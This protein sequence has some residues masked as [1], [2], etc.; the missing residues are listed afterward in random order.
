MEGPQVPQRPLLGRLRALWRHERTPQEGVRENNCHPRDGAIE[1]V[2]QLLKGTRDD[3]TDEGGPHI[4]ILNSGTEEEMTVIGYQSCPIR[5]TIYWCMVFLTVGIL[6]L[7]THWWQ[8]WLLIATHKCCPLATAQKVL[9]RELY[10][11]KHVIHFVCEIVTLS[12]DS[13]E[14][15][16]RYPRKWRRYILPRDIEDSTGTSLELSVPTGGGAFASVDT[17]RLFRCKQLRYIWRPSCNAFVR[18]TGLDDGVCSVALHRHKG[19]NP[20]EQKR[21]RMVFGSNEIDIPVKGVLTLLFLEVL[22]PFY[23]FQIFSVCLWF[24]YN[25]IWYAIVIVA[26]SVFGIT[27][28]VIQTR[29]NQRALMGTVGTTDWICVCREDGTAERIETR[30]LVPGDILEIPTTGC[31]MNCDAVLLSGNAI[32]DESSLTGES[33]PVTKTPLPCRREVIL[34]TK[35]HA[36]HM[37]FTGTKVIQTRYIGSEKVL[38][39]VINT[40]NSTVKGG[41]IRSI[42]YPPPVDYKFERDS[43]HFIKL[44]GLVATIGFL[45]TLISKII[46]GVSATKIAIES[47]DIIT[48]A[49]PP[50]LP[51]AMTVGRM[52][53][54]QRLKRK[55]IYCISPRSI[56]VSG[57]IDCVCF[58]KTGTLTEEGLDMWGVVP[59]DSQSLK[60][61]LRDVSRL[62]LG[63]LLSGMVTCHSITMMEGELK[64]DPLDLKMF[65]ST[66]W[67]LEE[68][69]V[70]DHSKYDLLFPTVVR[71]PDAIEGAAIGIVRSFPFTSTLQ[72]M[73]VITRGLTDTHF[74]VYCKGSPEMI[75]TLCQ[76]DTIPKDFHIKLDIYAQQGYRIIA[77]AFRPLDKKVSYARLQRLS[78][79]SVEQDLTFLGFVILENR[80]KGDTTTVISSL[81][82]A[83]IRTVMVTGD[84]ILTAISVAKD[85]GMIPKHQS[86]ITV[87]VKSTRDTH[88]LYYNLTNSSLPGANQA[89]NSM[90]HDSIDSLYTADTCTTTHTTLT[91]HEMECGRSEEYDD[92]TMLPPDLPSN[93]YRFAMTGRTWAI[94]RQ[95][96]PDLLQRFTTR[97]VVF[98]RMSP[99]Q[100]QALVAELQGLGYYVAMCGDGANDCG[101]LKT[102][103]TGISLSEAESSV[104]SPFTSRNPTIACVLDVI[105]EGRAALVTSFGIFK[106]MAAYSLVQF[107]SVLILYSIDSNLT[108]LQY[109]YIDLFIISVFAFFFGKTDAYAG[110]LVK[111]TPQNSLISIS[112]LTSIALHLII[113]IG[114][115]VFAWYHVQAQPWFVP[116]NATAHADEFDHGCLENYTIFSI[117]CF[118]YIIL[119]FVFSKGAPYR[120]SIITNY[121]FLTAMV[122]NTAF[123]LLLLIYPP[124]GLASILELIVPPDINF[125]LTLVAC[126]ALHWILAVVVE[127]FIVEVVVLKKLRNKFRGPSPRRKYIQVEQFLRQNP[128]WPPLTVLAP[129]GGASGTPS[130][131]PVPSAPTS[132]TSYAEIG[133]HAAFDRSSVLLTLLP[134]PGGVTLNPAGLRVPPAPS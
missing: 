125:R 62:P 41:L 72:R 87:N 83:N 33:V 50:A 103:H 2:A 65:E 98:A 67:V 8:H 43:Y 56:N 23:V 68:A 38:A 3:P 78:R 91:I 70:E 63:H 32:L 111:Q 109:L 25:Y 95:H 69:N 82:R 46:R 22:N 121:G 102:A 48:I 28:S 39:L 85:C 112:P 55:A 42:L 76:A 36:R 79:E 64:G 96:F 59:A 86:V 45:Y 1:Q 84:N 80:L 115:Q 47:L 88:E 40:G 105:R 15:I 122:V 118:Q 74:T 37:L 131:A 20:V 108:D 119:A 81:M 9:V 19:L 132:P 120:S 44:L 13:I 17:V 5:T 89:L 51:A 99:D 107:T 21:R 73:S 90:N 27:M 71:P 49:V 10:Q 24:S 34:C 106:Y 110:D 54:Q 18:L 14:E 127:T 100:K 97:G 52:N 128:A 129:F 101:A 4:G 30:F 66:G 11:G 60:A 75:H 116:F 104:A 133:A 113:S 114:F 57:S 134:N 29:R 93:N 6:R 35:E 12:T 94:V 123:T 53:A 7:V 31:Q 58:D 16:R 117:S 77:V 26:M 130:D 124:A 92:A 61:A 126:G